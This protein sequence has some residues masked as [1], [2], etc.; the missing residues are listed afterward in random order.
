MSLNAMFRVENI[1]LTV[2]ITLSTPG[3]P[4][5]RHL[6]VQNNKLNIYITIYTLK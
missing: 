5:S 6:T 1:E 3:T 4:N 2:F